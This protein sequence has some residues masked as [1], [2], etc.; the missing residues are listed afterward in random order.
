[1]LLDDADFLRRQYASPDRLA[2]RMSVWVDDPASPSP[3]DVALAALAE[4]PIARLLEVGCG[5]GAFAS[6]CQSVLGC[7]VQALDQS[8]SMV[9]R[10]RARGV[11]AEVGRVEEL[12]YES[13]V[14]DAVVAAWM[15]YHVRE[16]ERA[17][18]EIARVLRPGGRLVAI[19][20]GRGH[21]G[22]MWAALGETPPEPSFRRDNGLDLLQPW[23][24]TVTRR[25]LTTRAV[26]A[27]RASIDAY[28]RSVDVN[29]APDRLAVFPE[30]FAA[31]GEPTVFIADV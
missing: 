16:L 25:D 18:S 13:G 27:G 28:L 9:E 26:F 3:Q 30:P 4:L 2:T 11:E 15:L 8:A 21:L 7:H 10:A 19:T 17:L 29:V 22:E 23:F 12:P 31:H 6:H 1:M 5:T 14:F 20:N 24:R